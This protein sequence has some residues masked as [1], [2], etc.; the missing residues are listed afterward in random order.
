MMSVV[1]QLAEHDGP[2]RPPGSDGVVALA[3]GDRACTPPRGLPGP[4][5]ASSRC[6]GP[7]SMTSSPGPPSSWSLPSPPQTESLPDLQTGG[8]TPRPVDR[9]VRPGRPCSELD[10]VVAVEGVVAGTALRSGRRRSDPIL[11]GDGPCSSPGP[12][13]DDAVVVTSREHVLSLHRRRS[14][15]RRRPPLTS[16]SPRPATI[17]SR[18]S[19]RVDA[20]VAVTASA[21]S[22]RDRAIRRSRSAEDPPLPVRHDD[23]SPVP[24]LPKSTPVRGSGCRAR[25][26]VGDVPS[27]HDC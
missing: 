14:R 15:R 18:P 9:V 6:S 23:A 27:A 19:G 8:R 13:L 7:A 24:A 25:T 11:A 4:N 1:A 5:S 10:P 20:V 2:R 22:R 26:T 21:T 12:P 17:W 16:S 3:S